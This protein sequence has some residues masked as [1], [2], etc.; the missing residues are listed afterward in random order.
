MNFW[1]KL[2]LS[3]I[4]FFQ[5]AQIAP[6]PLKDSQWKISKKRGVEKYCSCDKAC[7]FWA[8][9][10]ISRVIWKTGQLTTKT[11]RSEFD[12]NIHQVIC[13]FIMTCNTMFPLHRIGFYNIVKTIRYN[14]KRIRHTTLYNATCFH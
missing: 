1:W 8:L 14:G 3:K 7:Q 4:M 6:L 5:Y 11:W 12:F 9:Y 13:A 10:C 2:Y